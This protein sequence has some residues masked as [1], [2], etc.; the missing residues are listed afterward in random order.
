[1]KEK[2][3]LAEDYPAMRAMLAEILLREF[4][5]VASVESGTAAVKLAVEAGPDVVILDVRMPDVDGIE[6][7][8]RLKEQGCNAKIVF[9]S[10]SESANQIAACFAAGGD[11]YVSKLRLAT[12]LNQAV[13]KVLAGEKFISAMR[14]ISLPQETAVS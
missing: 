3:L 10:V 4:D 11:A 5:L 12:D 14:G 7:A 9:V 13:K 6:V 8:Y 2:V 1:M